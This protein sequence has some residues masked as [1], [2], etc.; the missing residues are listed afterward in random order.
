MMIGLPA[1]AWSLWAGIRRRRRDALA[2]ALLYIVCLGM[3]TVSGKPIQFYYHYLLPGTFLMACL[4]LALD[5]LWRD[6]GSRRAAAITALCVAI[7][8]FAWFYPII[9]SAAL[10]GGDQSFL[11]W[12]WLKGWP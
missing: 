12:M 5:Q 9:S 6:G 8:M 10:P 1:L 2:F 3:W 11:R 4:A 7:G